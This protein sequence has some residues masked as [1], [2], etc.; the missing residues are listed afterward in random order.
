MARSQRKTPIC[1]IT[2]ARSDKADKIKAHRRER[3]LV[4][5]TLVAD[6]EAGVFPLEREISNPWNMAKDG[7][8]R[9]DPV[10]LYRLMR[11]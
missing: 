11:K 7:K 9:F 1:G 2:T 4:S 8:L 5:L 3:R 6:P 10:R